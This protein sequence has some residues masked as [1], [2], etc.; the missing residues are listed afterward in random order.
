MLAAAMQEQEQGVNPASLLQMKSDSLS[1][2]LVAEL[3]RELSILRTDYNGM[4]DH[5]S[6]S[7]FFIEEQGVGVNYC[8]SATVSLN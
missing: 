1:S 2:E 3:R 4:V 5:Y 7:W 6:E 8:Q